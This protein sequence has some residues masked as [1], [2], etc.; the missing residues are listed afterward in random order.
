MYGLYVKI[1]RWFIIDEL[2]KYN[3]RS[4]VN[5][6]L[7]RIKN[8]NKVSKYNLGTRIGCSFSDTK[9]II[10][11]HSRSQVVLGNVHVNVPKCNLGT[12]IGYSFSD[13]KP[14]ITKRSRSQVALGNAYV[15]VPKC[16][17]GTRIA[18]RNI[19]IQDTL[20]TVGD[21]YIPCKPNPAEFDAAFSHAEAKYI[22]SEIW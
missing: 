21:W 11:K 8:W 18:I 20:H 4:G 10:T 9:H 14:T 13:I 17:L 12:R 5:L 6:Y 16:N 15:K 2:M 3:P 22:D 7:L 1:G 19:E